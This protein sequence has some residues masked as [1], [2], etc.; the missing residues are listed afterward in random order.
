MPQ[1][2][3]ARMQDMDYSSHQMVE[4]EIQYRAEINYRLNASQQTT[5]VPDIDPAFQQSEFPQ[6]TYDAAT[7]S[8]I[9]SKDDHP[10]L[11]H[12]M[13]NPPANQHAFR[14]AVSKGLP[15]VGP[16]WLTSLQ[17]ATIKDITDI[18]QAYYRFV[19]RPELDQLAVSVEHCI[20]HAAERRFRAQVGAKR[21]GARG[22][23]G[24]DE[25]VETLHGGRWL[26][27][28]HAARGQS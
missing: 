7:Y 15:G 20:Q 26:A 16:E 1:S 12:D 19:A 9:Q 27:R 18:V 3:S 4:R 23:S 22:P 17:P 10:M 11:R 13:L 24:T 25:V 8:L 21:P 6:G 14:D 2:Y 28:Q 5:F